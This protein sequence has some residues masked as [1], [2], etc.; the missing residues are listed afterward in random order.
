MRHKL[1]ITAAALTLVAGSNAALAQGSRQG[2]GASQP[3]VF[4]SSPGGAGATR[5]LTRSLRDG[6]RSFQ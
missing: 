3:G 2:G 6:F 5:Q 4:E 1:L